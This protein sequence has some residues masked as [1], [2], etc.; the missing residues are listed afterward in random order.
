MRSTCEIK[1]ACSDTDCGN[2]ET[3]DAAYVGPITGTAFE[4]CGG[5]LTDDPGACSE[6]GAQLVVAP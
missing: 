1:V 6:C 4:D 2:V 3:L 5:R